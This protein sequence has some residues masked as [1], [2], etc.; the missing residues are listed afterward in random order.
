MIIIRSVINTVL[1]LIKML[2]SNLIVKAY[3]KKQFEELLLQNEDRYKGECFMLTTKFGWTYQQIDTI[4][5]NSVEL[6][7]FNTLEEAAKI[8]QP[9]YNTP[10]EDVYSSRGRLVCKIENNTVLKVIDCYNAFEYGLGYEL[11]TLN[12]NTGEFMPL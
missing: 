12:V 9:I 5:D 2:K 4:K 11:G 10:I 8:L 3:I 6:I 1:K 7:F